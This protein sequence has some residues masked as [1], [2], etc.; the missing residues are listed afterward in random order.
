MDVLDGRLVGLSEKG[1]SGSGGPRQQDS[2]PYRAQV[3]L[4][5]CAPSRSQLMSILKVWVALRQKAASDSEGTVLARRG[6]RQG[7]VS[8]RRQK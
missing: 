2:Q 7:P 1:G 8:E 5:V 3:I 4:R 6:I